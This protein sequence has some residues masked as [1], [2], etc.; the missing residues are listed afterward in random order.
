MIFESFETQLTQEQ[1]TIWRSLN[2]PYLIQQYLD[3]I[4]YRRE[5][6]DRSPLNVIRD[7]QGH[8]LDGGLFA[9]AALHRIGFKALILDLVPE[10][11]IDDDHV[12]AIFK[13]RGLLD[14]K[15]VV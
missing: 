9:A 1:L 14:R 2:T 8:C 10:P 12:L 4:A 15:S 7:S 13:K 5:E 6:R 11:G 3:G